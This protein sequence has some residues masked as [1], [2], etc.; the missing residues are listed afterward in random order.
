MPHYSGLFLK[1]LR[2]SQAKHTTD[3]D[4]SEV[5][6]A[7]LIYM[8]DSK[9]GNLENTGV[10]KK[11]LASARGAFENV[12]KSPIHIEEVKYNNCAFDTNL[13]KKHK[14]FHF[15]RTEL[16]GDI[17]GVSFLIFS[18]DEVRAIIKN[19]LAK[20]YWRGESDAQKQMRAQFISE[21]DNILASSVITEIANGLDQFVYG[22]VPK[23]EFIDGDQVNSFLTSEAKNYTNVFQFKAVFHGEELQISPRFVWMFNHE[24]IEKLKAA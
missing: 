10:F 12:I 22:G 17:A 18:D 7:K 20:E 6:S 13:L 14:T 23:L 19:C 11:G 2:V 3:R 16:Q 21:I 4:Y 1:L 5:Q 9:A 15:V 8:E 24:I